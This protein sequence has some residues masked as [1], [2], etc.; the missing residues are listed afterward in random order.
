MKSPYEILLI[1]RIT[2]RTLRL[3]EGGQ[4]T[5]IVAD[6]ANKIDIARAVE[7][8]YNSGKSKDKIKVVGVN[9][10]NVRGKIKSRMRFKKPGRTPKFKKA[11]IRLA[12]GQTLPD[13]GV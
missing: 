9:T 1:P 4:Y 6:D 10:I 11:I 12:P 3:V 7:E 2:E 5:F 8:H 13:F